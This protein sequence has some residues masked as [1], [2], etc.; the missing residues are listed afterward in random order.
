[1]VCF[2]R[3]AVEAVPHAV[4]ASCPALQETFGALG[5]ESVMARPCTAGRHH[6][7]ARPFT[8]WESSRTGLGLRPMSIG[9]TTL[10]A[11]PVRSWQR[12]SGWSSR[13]A[14]SRSPGHCPEVQ[15]RERAREV[16]SHI[17]AQG[18]EV[19][20]LPISRVAMESHI[21]GM[22][23]HDVSILSIATLSRSLRTSIFARSCQVSMS[24]GGRP[25]IPLLGGMPRSERIGTARV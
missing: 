13:R 11:R 25:V 12:G 21:L 18:G 17:A 4:R 9:P 15:L 16:D 10:P 19:C 14:R 1:M 5:R 2:V 3:P 7:S 22:C 24:S 20:R 23:S 8:G 6:H